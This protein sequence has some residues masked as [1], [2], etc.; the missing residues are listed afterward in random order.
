VRI[1]FRRL[2][3]H[4]KHTLSSTSA[5]SGRL[6]AMHKDQKRCQAE[7]PYL[8]V[9]HTDWQTKTPAQ[10]VYYRFPFY[11]QNYNDRRSIFVCSSSSR[12]GWFVPLVVLHKLAMGYSNN[13]GYV[14]KCV[15]MVGKG[16]D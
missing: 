11:W 5:T 7:N 13:V 4:R 8:P 1:T 16:D 12:R 6:S 9:R 14:V 3:Y 15:G 10:R 2:G